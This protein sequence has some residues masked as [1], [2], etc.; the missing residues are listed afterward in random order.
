MVGL[1]TNTN[2]KKI[3]RNRVNYEAIRP[4]LERFVQ[5]LNWKMP[6]SWLKKKRFYDFLFMDVL[7]WVINLFVQKDENE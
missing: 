5:E 7:Q 2:Q 4:F 6:E 3:K 1:T